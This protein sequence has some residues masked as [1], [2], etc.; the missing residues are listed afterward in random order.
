MCV[1]LCVEL[2][3]PVCV[4]LSAAKR[5]VLFCVPVCACVFLCACVVYIT[6]TLRVCG[7][8]IYVYLSL[9]VNMSCMSISH[10]LYVNM[11]CMSISYDF[12]VHMSSLSLSRSLC[13]VFAD[14]AA[15]AVTYEIFT[16]D[17]QTPGL[18][19]YHKRVQTF[20]VW[21]I[22]AAQYFDEIEDERRRFYYVFENRH[23]RRTFVGY[24][25]SPSRCVVHR[26]RHLV[27]ISK[28]PLVGCFRPAALSVLCVNCV[29]ACGRTTPILCCTAWQSAH[30]CVNEHVWIFLCIQRACH[31][32]NERRALL[33]AYVGS[34]F[35]IVP[36]LLLAT[37]VTHMHTLVLCGQG[38]DGVQ[39]LRL[40]G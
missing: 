13:V 29:E 9:S 35:L 20:F 7:Y 40:V 25:I 32:L 5:G 23:S 31:G 16:G 28:F 19:A 30:V 34:V 18:I 12:C 24:S 8:A 26:T 6:L 2:Y 36:W 21:F 38:C 10:N 14:D 33:K 39:L 3:M 22:E 1:Y 17:A 27:E 15:G 11:L 4:Q 37:S